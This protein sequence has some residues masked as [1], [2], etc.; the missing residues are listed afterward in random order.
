MDKEPVDVAD[1]LDCTH[2]VIRSINGFEREAKDISDA[3]AEILELREQTVI[4]CRNLAE[5]WHEIANLRSLLS[6]MGKDAERLRA[7]ENALRIV[8]GWLEFATADAVKYLVPYNGCGAT[9]FINR[10]LG[11]LDGPTQ[12]LMDAAIDAALPAP[13]KGEV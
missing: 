10:M 9:W 12:R 11:H 2:Q 7:S 5:Q 1:R 8:R 4:H 3:L 13:S 6:V